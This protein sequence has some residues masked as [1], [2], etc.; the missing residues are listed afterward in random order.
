[1][2]ANFAGAFAVAV[3]V[4]TAGCGGAARVSAGGAEAQAKPPDCEIEFLEK[5]PKR[6]FDELGELTA[7][8]NPGDAGR[9]VDALREPACRLGADAVIV[10]R[11]IV[12]NM[13]GN[14]LVAGRAI[15]YAPPPPAEAQ[16][17]PAEPKPEG[18]PP[19]APPRA[20]PGT[21]TL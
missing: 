2:R 10:T 9:A 13:L 18:E 1:M 21:I 19:P 7:T 12:T 5:A 6:P 17:A 20:A 15:R 4:A 3:S 8:V 11:R 16:P 14:T